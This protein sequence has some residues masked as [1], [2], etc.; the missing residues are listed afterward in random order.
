MKALEKFGRDWLKVQRFVKTRTLNQV[1]S[2]AQ[3]VFLK[4]SDQD[5][6][7]LIRG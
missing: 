5:I 6:E 4:M 1:R 3:K 2:H 7:S